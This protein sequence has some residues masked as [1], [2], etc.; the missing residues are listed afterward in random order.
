ML[1][2]YSRCV[3]TALVYCGT[4]EGFVIG[5][6]SRGSDP[7]TKKVTTDNERKIYSFQVPSLSLVF[8]WSGIVA[9]KTPDFD[10]SLIQTTTDILP[11]V[12]VRSFESDFNSR[13]Q[14][15]ISV[16]KVKTTGECARGIFLYFWKGAPMMFEISV[17]KNGNSWDSYV[18]KSTAAPSEGISIISG[19]AA[20][21][22][23]PTSLNQ[24][25]NM[26]EAY[27]RSSIADKKIL[28][29]GGDPH[30]GKLSLNGFEWILAPK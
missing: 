4:A 6:D 29:I 12:D 23:K 22:E 25:K 16:L 21:F 15:K 13:L 20:K 19:P 14:D 18:S 17:F 7:A 24:A 8:A 11:K 28:D 27:I 30:I 2:P 9:A 5:T 3:S 10:F 1:S 26:I